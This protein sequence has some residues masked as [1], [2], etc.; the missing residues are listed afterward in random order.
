MSCIEKCI[1][2]NAVQER[3]LLVVSFFSCGYERYFSYI[4]SG[5]MF[6]VYFALEAVSII[7]KSYL[8]YSIRF[9]LKLMC[10]HA[11]ECVCVCGYECIRECMKARARM[12]MCLNTSLRV[13]PCLNP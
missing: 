9:S 10:K 12:C 2:F 4:L 11:S 8:L 3:I 13:V 1:Y 6:F 5:L 7:I